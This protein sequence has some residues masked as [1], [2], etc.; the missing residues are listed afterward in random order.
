MAAS[1]LQ[2]LC[3]KQVNSS[4]AAS[5][6]CPLSYLRSSFLASLPVASYVPDPRASLGFLIH[7]KAVFCFK[8][9]APISFVWN[10][11][12]PSALSSS[13]LSEAFLTHL[14]QSTSSSHS[15]SLFITASS[16]FLSGCLF[17][18]IVSRHIYLS[19]VSL[20]HQMALQGA[21]T[22][23]TYLIH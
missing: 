14:I 21:R 16:L 7:P 12:P 19:I 11:L 3:T 10:T 4:S 5:D 13:Y 23:A 1:G 22:M 17:Q 8:A 2:K 6:S 18:F 9:S 20:S 15:N